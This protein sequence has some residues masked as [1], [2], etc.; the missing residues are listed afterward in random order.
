MTSGRW[1][2]ASVIVA[3]I[4]AGA[5]RSVGDGGSREDVAQPDVASCAEDSAATITVLENDAPGARVLWFGQGSHGVVTTSGAGALVYTPAPDW[6]GEDT[7]LYVGAADG[8]SA[9]VAVTVTVAPVNDLPHAE[10]DLLELRAGFS[11][12]FDPRVNDV[13][14]DAEALVVSSAGLAAQGTVTL[15]T[16]GGLVYQ[17]RPGWIGLD[18]FTYR[19]DD[20]SGGSAQGRVRAMVRGWPISRLTFAPAPNYEGPV[21]DGEGRRVVFTGYSASLVP[22]DANGVSD[23]FLV[24]RETGSAERVSLSDAEAEANGPSEAAAISSSG[25]VVAFQSIAT[26]LVVGDLNLT[27]DVFIR[28]IAL[29]TTERVSLSSTGGELAFGAD[30]PSL[31]ADGNRVAFVGYGDGIV[32]G[33]TNGLPDVF[34]R[35]RLAGTTVRA[36]LADDE[37][38]PNGFVVSPR[39]SGDG[40]FVIFLSDATNLVAGDTNGLRDVFVR[41]LA[42]QTTARV[43]V[44]SNGVQANADASF[45][46]ISGD[47]QVV[48]FTSNATGLVAGDTN[49]TSDVFVR[50]AGTTTRVSV[51]PNGAE[52]PDGGWA[53]AGMLSANGRYVVFQ[54]YGEGLVPAPVGG[55]Y[56]AFVHDRMTGETWLLSRDVAAAD[57]NVDWVS[58]SANGRTAVFESSASNL[59]SPHTSG[60]DEI[61]AVD[62]FST[63]SSQ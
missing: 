51:G 29:G 27:G 44:A 28:D 7:F 41:D 17:P 33:D 21:A 48:A 20:E 53:A 56:E 25:S 24:D 36:S 46:T 22:G 1:Q 35:D 38:E 54:S 62:L 18:E 8:A 14:P 50:E 23:V 4:F 61:F 3:S 16:A 57:G 13:D 42:A 47:G 37:A 5:C 9:S 49:G 6:S 40:Q 31:S 52:S 11:A 43:N 30:S 58:L 59:V 15:G 45:A 19:I 55:A 26:N 34:V 32:P 60:S 63:E 10:D 12:S 2:W 39:I